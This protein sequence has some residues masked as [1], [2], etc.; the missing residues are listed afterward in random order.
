MSNQK[1]TCIRGNLQYLC[2]R[3]SKELH[4]KHTSFNSRNIKL[5][6]SQTPRK[7]KRRK[8]YNSGLMT[9]SAS[10]DNALDLFC[11]LVEVYGN[12]G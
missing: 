6:D 1:E 10:F 3:G 9:A 8:R 7:Q 2:V 5:V 12:R 4:R 11:D